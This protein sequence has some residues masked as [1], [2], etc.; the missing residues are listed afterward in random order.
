MAGEKPQTAGSEAG[1]RNKTS[2]LREEGQCGY[3]PDKLQG[4]GQEEYE[5]GDCREEAAEVLAHELQDEGQGTG[6]NSAGL[7]AREVGKEPILSPRW[8]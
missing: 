3:W 5:L 1:D 4:A 8:R 7:Q 6:E 2:E